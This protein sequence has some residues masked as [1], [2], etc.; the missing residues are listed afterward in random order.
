MHDAFT[1]EF[2]VNLELQFTIEW[3]FQSGSK[4]LED[5]FTYA[6]NIGEEVIWRVEV[7][8]ALLASASYTGPASETHHATWRFS[9]GAGLA[10]T[11]NSGSGSAFSAEDA[12]WGA[13]FNDI[14]ADVNGNGDGEGSLATG[15]GHQNYNAG[16][17]G[18]CST[19]YADGVAHGSDYIENVMKI[20]RPLPTL[21]HVFSRSIDPS[22]F[23]DKTT[24]AMSELQV[25]EIIQ[26][27]DIHGNL[28]FAPIIRLPHKA[29]NSEMA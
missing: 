20:G 7:A 29:G 12:S 21:E 4:T 11:F 17:A 19:W 18:S 10:N 13:A 16:D 6:E 28:D 26:T 27:S 25:G 8:P 14:N 15:W 22:D 1:Q 5:R 2:Y 9:N 24:K 3:D 23:E